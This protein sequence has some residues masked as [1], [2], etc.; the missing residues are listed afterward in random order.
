MGRRAG[1][2]TRAVLALAL[3]AAVAG[4][5]GGRDPAGPPAASDAAGRKRQ[6]GKGGFTVEYRTGGKAAR[7]TAYLRAHRVLETA[8]ERLNGALA[9]PHRIPFV[10]RSCGAAEPAYDPETGGIDF[11][12]EHV[13]EI[14]DRFAH[15]GRDAAGAGGPADGDAHTAAVLEETAYHEGAHALIDRLGLRFTGR[16]EDVADQFAAV[17]L[18]GQGRTGETKALA[19]ATDY[20]L[21]AEE[22]PFDPADLLDEHSL[23]G[24]RAAAYA[25]YVY[26]AHPD[27]HQDLVGAGRRVTADRAEGCPE[28]WAQARDGWQR[29]LQPHLKHAL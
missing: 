9:L 8:A 13:D 3:A 25:C 21:A 12:A 26:G 17:L 23:D 16:E 1:N 18:L 20:A 6:T 29:L 4:C 28:E 2:G 15:T 27:R 14:R 22:T 19:V 7:A 11:C 10:V 5:A 24:Q